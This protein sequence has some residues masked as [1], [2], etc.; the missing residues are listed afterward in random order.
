MMVAKRSLVVAKTTGRSERSGTA[1]SAAAEGVGALK[2]A[3]KSE[4]VKSVSWPIPL[5]TG[6]W[7]AKIALA[8]PSSLNAQRSSIDPPP[9]ATMIR[10]MS[11]RPSNQRMAWM[12]CRE[13]I[14]LYSLP[15]NFAFSVGGA[16]LLRYRTRPGANDADRDR[17]IARSDGSK[18]S[19]RSGS[20][21]GRR[22][23]AHPDSCCL[24]RFCLYVPSIFAFWA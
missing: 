18:S 22:A 2:S 12:I 11:S 19:S 10:S 13:R 21:N 3:T 8:T 15:G 20:P 4:I 23:P 6:C 7:A 17:C 16:I 5:I 24:R 1:S 9:R 14:P